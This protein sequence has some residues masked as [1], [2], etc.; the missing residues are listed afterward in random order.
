MFREYLK[1]YFLAGL[2]LICGCNTLKGTAK[3]FSEGIKQDVQ[4]SG[5]SIMKAD[6]WFQEHYW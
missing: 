3:G 2:V 5:S 4:I 6:K 1:F